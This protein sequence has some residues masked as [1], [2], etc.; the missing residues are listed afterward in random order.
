MSTKYC[1]RPA[2]LEAASITDTI[3]VKGIVLIVDVLT[4]TKMIPPRLLSFVDQRRTR[5]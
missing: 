4:S 2:L 3:I 5:L 1:K